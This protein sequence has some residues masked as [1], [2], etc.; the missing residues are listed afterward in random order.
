[1][2]NITK[3]YLEEKLKKEIRDELL[4]EIKKVKS[5]KELEIFLSKIF[6]PAEIIMIEKRIGVPYLLKKGLTYRKICLDLDISLS[7]ISFIKKGFKKPVKRNVNKK[8]K[9]PAV[10]EWMLK[11]NSKFPT[12][13]S[14]KGRWKGI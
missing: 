6:T 1:M 5:E 7:T 3:I 4:K 12:S 9:E 8:M 2:V 10:S 11:K 14:G 13:Y